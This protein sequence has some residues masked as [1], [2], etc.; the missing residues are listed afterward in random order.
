[1]TPVLKLTAN[2]YDTHINQGGKL[3][4]VKFGA[5]WCG[6]C[7]AIEPILESLAKKY[8]NTLDVYEVD[9]DSEPQIANRYSVRG[10]PAVFLI[11]DGQVLDSFTGVMGQSEVEKMLDNHV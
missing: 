11:K 2:D 4:L 3:K 9:V 6:P 8:Q 10:I 7:R 1:M 5:A